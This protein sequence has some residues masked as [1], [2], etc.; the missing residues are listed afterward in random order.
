[1]GAVPVAEQLP[2]PSTMSPADAYLVGDPGFYDIYVIAGTASNNYAWYNAGP[3]AVGTTVFVAGQPVNTFDA[4]TKLDKV[5]T[6][7]TKLRLYAIGTNGQQQLE[8]A[9]PQPVAYTTARRGAGGVLNVGAPTA[10]SHAT[11]KKYVD[12]KVETAQSSIWKTITAPISGAGTIDNLPA[13]DFSS[14]GIQQVI[15]HVAYPDQW[16]NR[17]DFYMPISDTVAFRTYRMFIPVKE[18]SDGTLTNKKFYITFAQNGSPTEC[19]IGGISP[20]EWGDTY[21]STFYIELTYIYK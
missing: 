12:D 3:M 21:G 7:S 19:S 11:T 17:F 10:D 8:T 5:S 16:G 6:T 1:M 15:V 14:A 18:N 20:G 4:D 2:D 13:M 9:D